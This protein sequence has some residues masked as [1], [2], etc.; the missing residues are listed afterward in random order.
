MI[1]SNLFSLVASLA[2]LSLPICGTQ[3]SEQRTPQ[4]PRPIRAATPPEPID[5]PEAGASPR[6]VNAMQSRMKIRPITSISIDTSLPE[7]TLPPNPAAEAFAG[8]PVTNTST[9]SRQA[10]LRFSHTNPALG[11]CH[12]P[13]YFEQPLMERYGRGPARCGC[14]ISAAHFFG[15]IPM[16]PYKMVMQRPRECVPSWRCRSCR[17]EF[18]RSPRS[19]RAAATQAIVTAGL[20]LALP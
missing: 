10:P 9:E 4:L 12:Q 15:S 7:G 16:L 19:R 2:F 17:D 8:E 14:V 3:A 13:L 6:P 18:L 5:V 20:L 11:F 1:R